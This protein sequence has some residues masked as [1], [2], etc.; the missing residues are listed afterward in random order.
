MLN[1]ISLV[2]K[3][4]GSLDGLKFILNFL[5]EIISSLDKAIIQLNNPIKIALFIEI[6]KDAAEKFIRDPKE[7]VIAYSLGVNCG[8]PQKWEDNMIYKEVLKY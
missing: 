3:L 7:L 6:A 4:K 5:G 2:S 1:N 8:D